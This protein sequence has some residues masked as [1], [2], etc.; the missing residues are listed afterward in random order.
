[1]PYTLVQITDCHLGKKQHDTLLGLDADLSLSLVLERLNQSFPKVDAL[2]CSGD[3]S[4]ESDTI[5]PY[6]RLDACLPKQVP[7]YW[8]PGNHDENALMEAYLQASHQFLGDFA[9]GNWHV[10]LLDS[11]VLNEVGG[12]LAIAEIERAVAVLEKYPEKHH[13]I[14]LHHHLKPVG[15]KWLDGQRVSNADDA[16]AVFTRYP[17]L[18]M[19]VCGHVHQESQQTAGHVQLYSTPSTCIQFKPHSEQ[20]AVGAEMPGFRWFLLHD[21]GRYQTGVTRIEQQDLSIDFAS[22]GY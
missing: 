7:Q 5:E 15:C 13:I 18:K 22:A 14:F 19:L 4:N 10:T 17:Q 20:F 2:V 3:L 16:L 11:S 8:L 12:F 9:L 21:D 1:M 6:Q